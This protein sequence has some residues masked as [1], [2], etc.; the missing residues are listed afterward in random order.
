[1][2]PDFECSLIPDVWFGVTLT[3]CCIIHDTSNLDTQSALDLGACVYQTMAQTNPVLAPAAA[4]V[5]FLFF[6]GPAVWC[7]IKYGPRGI[8]RR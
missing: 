5:G 8:K 2:N 3:P 7:G 6:L 4:V 1:M